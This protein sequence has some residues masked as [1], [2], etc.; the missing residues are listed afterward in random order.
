MARAIAI[1]P[2]VLLLSSC[3]FFRPIAGSASLDA[4]ALIT[5]T[6]G[7]S[8]RAPKGWEL[9][10]EDGSYFLQDPDQLVR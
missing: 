3:T 8:F 2:V 9:V 4:D 1:A 6:S 5:T 10:S 7:A